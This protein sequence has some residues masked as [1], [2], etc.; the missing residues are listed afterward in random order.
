MRIIMTH[1]HAASMQWWKRALQKTWWSSV[2]WM[3]CHNIMWPLNYTHTWIA[4]FSSSSSCHGTV[5]VCPQINA[6]HMMTAVKEP[7]TG[8][9]LWSCYAAVAALLLGLRAH[10]IWRA[11]IVVT[12]YY[13]VFIICIAQQLQ[14]G[15]GYEGKVQKNRGGNCKEEQSSKRTSWIWVYLEFCEGKGEQFPKGSF[16]LWSFY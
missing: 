5:S 11:R 6:H 14:W 4:M 15:C 16:N 2:N 3:V 7:C 8:H 9:V 12:I 1:D 10:S 13:I